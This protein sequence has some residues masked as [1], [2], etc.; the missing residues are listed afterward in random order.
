M[1]CSV[2]GT[3][4]TEY[5]YKQNDELLCEECI[6][7]IDMITISKNYYL[8]GEYIGNDCD[9]NEIYQNICDIAGYEEIENDFSEV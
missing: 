8:D 1:R 4:C 3:S 5:L 9:Y 7:E 6:L 2:C